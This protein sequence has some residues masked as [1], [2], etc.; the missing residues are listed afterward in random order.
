MIAIAIGGVFAYFKLDVF[1]ELQPHLTITQEVSIRQVGD[2]YV[3]IWVDVVLSNGSKVAVEIRDATFWIQHVTPF[4]DEEVE[5]IY[6]EFLKNPDTEKYMPFPTLDG[7][8]RKW[9][10]DEFIIE[11]GETETDRYEFV[12]G[13]EFKTVSVSCFFNR[14][15][16]EHGRGWA[17]ATIHDIN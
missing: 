5:D 17:A 11:P 2:S 14:N 4:S 16:P 1:R 6:A 12:V 10:P 7:F 15:E 8:N 9:A 3:L 13:R